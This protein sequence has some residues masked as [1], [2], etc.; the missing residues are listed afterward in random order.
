MSKMELLP[1]AIGQTAFTGLAASAYAS[2]DKAEIEGREFLVED[3]DYSTSPAKPRAFFGSSGANRFKRIRVVRNVTGL[4]VLSRQAVIFKGANYGQQVDGFCNLLAQETYLADEFLPA[5]GVP[6]NDLFYIT[7]DGCAEFLTSVAGD[8]TN[9]ITAAT[10]GANAGAGNWLVALTAAAS[11]AGTTAASTAITAG[12]LY[13]ATYGGAT[14]ALAA[15]IQN[16][17]GIALSA[18][19]TAQTNTACLCYVK[20]W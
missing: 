1:F 7:V 12:H 8:A 3:L 20:R 2:T 15:M 13:A 4:A 14:T 6:N 17:V 19:T 16:R 10:A 11:T 9:V 5:A 18:M